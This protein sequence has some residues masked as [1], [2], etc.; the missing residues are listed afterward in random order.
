M[1][2]SPVSLIIEITNPNHVGSPQIYEKD[3]YKKKSQTIT[4]GVKDVKK[5][6]PLYTVGDNINWYGYHEKWYVGD[7]KSVV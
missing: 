6:E 3:C 1:K 4:S 2:K 7:R 5:G